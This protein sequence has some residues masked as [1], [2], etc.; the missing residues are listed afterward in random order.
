MFHFSYVEQNDQ[1]PNDPTQ[2]IPNHEQ[3]QSPNS[4]FDPDC[5][6]IE[7]E[8]NSFDQSDDESDTS[9]LTASIARVNS[10][11]QLLED[12][13]TRLNGINKNMSA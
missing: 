2:Q 9:D 6:V 10:L 1:A 13:C 7:P 3:I 12:V 4:P 5:L 8:H 11:N